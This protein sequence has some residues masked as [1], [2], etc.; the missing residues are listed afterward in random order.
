MSHFL[1]MGY[2]MSKFSSPDDTMTWLIQWATVQFGEDV[3][4]ITA[5]IM[6]KYGI[7]T[8][9][10]KYEDLSITPFAFSA[11]EYDEAE[12]NY[13][14]W[15][16]LLNI[17]QVVH[18]KLPSLIQQPFFEMI[19]HPVQAG[20]NVFEIYSKAA[21]GARYASERRLRA[22]EMAQEA[23]DAFS[24]DQALTRKY[25]TMLNGKWNN[26]MSQT[27]IG[28]NNWQEPAQNS[29]PTLST[30]STTTASGKAY[31]VGIQGGT[32]GTTDAARVTTSLMTQYMPP[33]EKRFFD[34]FLRGK[35]S[36][37]YTV[38]SNS[39]FAKL[40]NMGGTIKPESGGPSQ[41]RSIVSIDWDAVPEGNSAAEFSIA[42]SDPAS[43]QATTV[44]VPLRKLPAAPQDFE[45]FV[46][47]NAAISI[48]ANHYFGVDGGSNA[49]NYVIIPDYGRTLAGV[50]LW[51]VTTSVQSPTAGPA[52]IYPFYTYSSATNAKV[53]VYLSSSENADSQRPNRYAISI[54]DKAPTIVQ[55]T[56]VSADAGQEPAGWDNA[57]TR[58][59]WIRDSNVGSLS[60]GKHTL[61]V[62]LLEPTMVL[63]KMVI[64][65]GGV[66]RSEL[67]P[68]ESFRKVFVN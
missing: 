56:P 27:H 44:V 7:L 39:S 64:D 6:T 55:P 41:L 34:V 13:Q 65:L 9:R 21:I 15:V 67:G 1:A 48:E 12:M 24:A 49:S 35:T 54:D 53:T 32:G 29:M 2:D 5:E 68:P 26:M 3:S 52:L 28:Y 17:T 8:A 10:R 43:T 40:S 38:T 60:A 19:L 62:W 11:T 37:T 47:A 14:E 20:K 16:E 33:N 23:R 58:N 51:P 4:R 42:V 25:H 31:G 57:V 66:K 59:A 30:L 45:G 63:T 50:K 46:E 18:D 22:N 36:V 61:K